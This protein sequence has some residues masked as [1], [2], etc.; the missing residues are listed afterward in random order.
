MV[1]RLIVGQERLQKLVLVYVHS[2]ICLRS[3][4]Y[5]ELDWVDGE[6]ISP[7]RYASVVA[8]SILGIDIWQPHDLEEMSLGV[9][10]NARGVATSCQSATV[11][12]EFFLPIIRQK[13][14][15][16]YFGC[17]HLFFTPPTKV[18]FIHDRSSPTDT[19]SFSRTAKL[20][21]P[22][23]YRTPVSFDGCENEIETSVFARFTSRIVFK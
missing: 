7:R 14:V 12:L 20:S 17:L 22:S 18:P 13:A 9:D 1:Q 8:V 11:K 15:W 4:W 6:W 16:I 10:R 5:W 2:H 19:I 23:D 21:V 3:P